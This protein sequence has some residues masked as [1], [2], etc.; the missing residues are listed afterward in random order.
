MSLFNNKKD[1]AATG[2]NTTNNET[3]QLF[4]ETA[5]PGQ[6]ALSMN[7]ED[8]VNLY[9]Q[10]RAKQISLDPRKRTITA[11]AGITIL[12]F[13][14]SCT[15]PTNVFDVSSRADRSLATL[16]AEF[17]SQAQAFLGVFT[18]GESLFSMHV[19]EVAAALIAGAAL[20]V[21]GGVYQGSLK[22][23]L[24]GPSTLGVTSGATLGLII[25]AVFAYNGL[26][27]GD[28][29]SYQ[30]YL[31]TL[32]LSDYIM[33]MYGSFLCSL[34]GCF[35][36]VGVVLAIA[37]VAGAGKVSNASVV[38]A[39]QVFA[40]VISVV[41]TW[42]RYYIEQTTNDAAVAEL[43]TQVQN[44]SFNGAYNLQ[45]VLVFG[46]PTLACIIAIFLLSPR[47]SLLSF[48]ADEARSMGISVNGTRIGMVALCTTLTA[49]TI[50]FVG[51]LGFVGFMMPHLARRLVGPDFRYLLPAAALLGA[52][53]ITAVHYVATL[54]I[55]GFVT[56]NTG[57]FTSIVGSIA[58]LCLIMRRKGV[59]SADWL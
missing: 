12:V 58:F 37:Y 25:Y 46:L 43:L 19:W 40:A 10:G 8:E 55:P 6:D 32:P 54:G 53:L 18:G 2:K 50:S 48:D 30:D 39:G 45:S 59:H 35:L 27:S 7:P 20:A 36:V 26:Y 5:A 57:T 24:A 23:A 1:T 28:L 47:L 3:P 52:I 14:L 42:L 4:Q 49:L 22:N 13:F 31:N 16:L 51:P 56:G 44:S 29:S 33:T 38:I 17:S 9:A 41:L 21:S 34:L 11:L 15:L